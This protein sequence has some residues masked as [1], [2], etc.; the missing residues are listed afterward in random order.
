[1]TPEQASRSGDERRPNPG[2]GGDHVRVVLLGRTGL[3]ASL[4]ED[5]SIEMVR[6]RTALEAVGEVAAPPASSRT[7]PTV[8]VVGQ[9]GEPTEHSAAFVSAIRDANPTAKLIRIEQG[10]N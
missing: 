5:A 7:M 1:M 10:R 3:D 8:V 9:G 2:A 6:A 4:R